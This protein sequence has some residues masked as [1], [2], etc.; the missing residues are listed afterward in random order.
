MIDVLSWYEILFGIGLNIGPGL[1][2]LFSFVNIKIGWWEI[3]ENNTV[4]VILVIVVSLIF[5][6][7]WFHIIDLSKELDLIRTE[8]SSTRNYSTEIETTAHLKRR[9]KSGLIKWTD[10]LQTDILLLAVSCGIIKCTVVYSIGTVTMITSNRFHWKMEA[11]AWLHTVLGSSSYLA[12]S[13][14]VKLS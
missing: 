5:C 10:F 8:F 3:N 4:P 7:S 12:T 6:I 11:H 9:S 1:P 14:L 13:I 2:V